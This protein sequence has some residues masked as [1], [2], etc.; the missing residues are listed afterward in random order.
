MFRQFSTLTE[1]LLDSTSSSDGVVVI[2]GHA[3]E[4]F[5][6]FHSIKET[7]LGILGELQTKGLTPGD[8]LVFQLGDIPSF[9]HHYWACILGGIIPVPLSVGRTPDQ[10]QK[11]ISVWSTLNNPYLIIQEADLPS[12][13]KAIY[14]EDDQFYHSLAGKMVYVSDNKGANPGLLYQARPDDIAYIQFSSGSTN[15]PKGIVLTHKNLITNCYA[16]LNGIDAPEQ[17]DSFFSW[18]P[19]THDMGLIGYHL[20]PFIA[21]WTHYIMPTELFIRRPKLWL[22]KISEHK[23]TFSASPNFG[24][25]YILD[26]VDEGLL[27][28]LDLSS[29]R[30]ITNGAEPISGSLCRDFLSRLSS[31]GLK[32]AVMFP[33]YGLAEASLAVTFSQPN[34]ELISLHLDRR[35]LVA[36]QKVM[37]G[38]N[39]DTLEV[40][41]LGKPLQDNCAVQIRHEG[42]VCEE[43]VIGSVFIKGNNVTKAYYN[44]PEQTSKAI[45]SDG[46]LDTGDLGFL[47]DK[48]LYI[49]GRQKD[50]I[51]INGQNY[52]PHDLEMSVE[53]I[54][55]Q[56]KIVFA[57]SRDQTHSEEDVIGFVIHKG[58]LDK[59]L[60]IAVNLKRR[61]NQVFGFFP[62]HLV[63]VTKIPKTTS[64]KVQRFKLARNYEKGQFSS[65]IEEVQQG[66]RQQYEPIDSNLPANDETAQLISLASSILQGVPLDP[67]Q[68]LYEQGF[69]S[70]R[71][72]QF[73]ASVKKELGVELRFR[74]LWEHPTLSGLGN[75]ISTAERIPFESI[76]ASHTL[77]QQALSPLQLGIYYF[78]ATNPQSTAYNVPIA[79]SVT[80][81]FDLANFN[82]AFKQVV[83]NHSILRTNFL[84]ELDQP[85]QVVRANSGYSIEDICINF[86]ELDEHIRSCIQPFDLAKDVLFRGFLFSGNQA[87]K[88]LFLD[89]HHIIFDGFSVYQLL[90]EV[91]Q[92]IEGGLSNS[93]RVQYSDYV[94]WQKEHAT[95]KAGDKQFWNEYLKVGCDALSLQ[96]DF[97]RPHERDFEGSTFSKTLPKSLTSRLFV[98]AQENQTTEYAILLA[99][100]SLFLTRFTHQ[101][102]VRVGIPANVRTHPDVQQAIGMFVNNLSFQFHAPELSTF[103][104]IVKKSSH[105]LMTLMEHQNYPYQS[106]VEDLPVS[107]DMSR[108]KLFDTMLVYQNFGEDHLQFSQTQLSRY[109]F[110]TGISKYDFSLEFLKGADRLQVQVEYATSLFKAS[111]AHQIYQL[112]VA[113]L[114][115]LL[116][117]PSTPTEQIGLAMGEQEEAPTRGAIDQLLPVNKQILQYAE[118]APHEVAIVE[119]NRNI[120]YQQLSSCSLAIAAEIIKLKNDTKAPVAI[121]L[122]RSSTFIVSTLGVL[123]SGRHYLPIDLSLPKERI[124][125]ILQDSGAN[126]IIGSEQTLS[127]LGLKESHITLIAEEF[128]EKPVLGNA[129]QAMG[130]KTNIADLAYVIY[131]SGTTGNPKGVE[132]SHS[133]LANY[134]GWCSENYHQTCSPPVY[135]F[136]SS[137]SFDLTITSIFSP[138]V[139]GGKIKVFQEREGEFVI[140]DVLRDSEITIL[141]LTPSHLKILNHSLADGPHNTS[142]ETLI[143]GG[144]ELLC[145]TAHQTLER[146]GQHV[147]LINEYGPTEA[148][149]G[150]MN[151]RFDPSSD[152]TGPVSIGT[153][154]DGMKALVLDSHM[155]P[156]PPG[157]VGEL[158]LCGVGLAKGYLGKPELTKEKFIENPFNPGERL[159]KTGDLVTVGYDSQLFFKGR[160]DNQVKVNGYRVELDEITESLMKLTGIDTAFV[161]IREMTGSSSIVAYITT[162]EIDFD[163]DTIGPQLSYW[164][165]EYMIP[166]S[167]IPVDFIPLTA[168]G[169]VDV[170]QLPVRH[171]SPQREKKFPVSDQEKIIVEVWSEVLDHHTISL[172]DSFFEIGGDSIKAVQVSSRLLDEDVSL[173]AKDILKYQ[174]V[175]NIIGAGVV[176]VA[177]NE[178][179]QGLVKGNKF[180]T[181]IEHWFLETPWVNSSHYNQSVLLNFR[182]T[183]DRTAVRAAFQ[184][185][186]NHHDGLRLAYS[187]SEASVVFGDAVS[188][189]TISV[190]ILEIAEENVDV[191]EDQITG[192]C[193]KL[194]AGLSLENRVLFRLGII[195][196]PNG[197]DKLFITIHHLLVDGLSWRI[198]LEDFK[199]AYQSLLLGRSIRLPKKTASLQLW[200]KYLK[201]TLVLEIDNSEVAYWHSM[202]SNYP[203]EKESSG[204]VFRS[205]GEELTVAPE[206]TEYLTHTA[207]SKLQVETQVLLLYMVYQVMSAISPNEDLFFELEH[208][209]RAV[210]G[211]DVSRTVGWFTVMYPFEVAIDKTLSRSEKIHAIQQSFSDVPS[212]GMGYMVSKYLTKKLKNKPVSLIRFNYLGAFGKE[213]SNELFFMNNQFTGSESDPRNPAT[214]NIEFNLLV[215]NKQ[216][217]IQINYNDRA[218]SEPQI[219][220]L[221]NLLADELIHTKMNLEAEFEKHDTQPD[222]FIGAQLDEEDLS[223]LFE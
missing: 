185:I 36:G 81:D 23:I 50:I 77:K 10:V 173:S 180:L 2:E 128:W 27:E 149:V 217:R 223:V 158:F 186:C 21:G 56:G 178:Y 161:T 92:L 126:I 14:K 182:D 200:G 127:E 207:P 212:N 37:S 206:L 120:T 135:A 133:A 213:L 94:A 116:T 155:N 203:H 211:I 139:S 62:K 143:V 90:Q 33:V 68:N 110:D 113:F 167:I 125:Y 191:Q 218:F 140:N 169:K 28:T 46:W 35:A 154:I 38:K 80:G 165:P 202:L 61:I 32:P 1:A 78:W 16:I 220:N 147:Q 189:E 44:N 96:T 60:P 108:D 198:L 79:F 204:G 222:Q 156:I 30:I 138:L 208:H 51:F 117:N 100:Y 48:C 20:S 9:I 118:S 216:L 144:E 104:D 89:F 163:L 91:F 107:S 192:F 52:Y 67:N 122:P 193:S 187:L 39:E 8:E 95:T 142:L 45:G 11:L 40:V 170:S 150:C 19:L 201:D 183:I 174:T 103:R 176:H 129:M 99:S 194:K 73:L 85:Y 72:G 152:T 134:I 195:Q 43:Q 115:R 57:G 168:N 214:A 106:M 171:N 76:K 17:G 112:Y 22:E 41:N 88:V 82:S 188:L 175:E 131:T 3:S 101:E 93:P 157:G 86:A 29:L 26:H 141:K 148:A 31:T 83:E 221:R 54:V 59:F 166:R 7:A 190:D 105:D 151:Y 184:A 15:S 69:N 6:S 75:L 24:Y 219:N 177:A 160:V 146:L 84:Y 109:R 102:S 181:P 130:V 18:M 5:L 53:D 25:K 137:V 63:P 196:M 47:K 42:L 64:G 12:F 132:L 98:F 13:K 66:I 172:S 74:D 199:S 205:L 215:I 209:G 121:L 123:N 124:Q 111:S 136:Y 4:S 71:A 114:E 210:E 164:L 65:V 145:S 153:P 55:A 162:S 97:P 119:K 34:E 70:L 179:D 58:K 87:E 197:R 49:T 159:Y